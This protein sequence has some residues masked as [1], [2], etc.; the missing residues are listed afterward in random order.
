MKLGKLKQ[1]EESLKKIL[2]ADLPIQEAY[3][4]S[5]MVA[6]VSEELTAAEKMRVD[7]VIKKYGTQKEDKT[8]FI[9]PEK[10]EEFYNEY[11]KLLET[12]VD[13]PIVKIKM[14]T[15]NGTK[16]SPID[17]HNL[18]FIFEEEQEKK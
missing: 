3:K 14:E 11:N 10:L 5:R 16:L 9:Q 13:V 7:L 2:N 8:W 18:D 15:L 17:L 1:A 6:R 12:E 4:L